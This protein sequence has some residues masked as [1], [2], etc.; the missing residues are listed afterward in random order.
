M[1][2]GQGAFEYLMTY[3]WAILVVLVIGVALWY[4]GV[5]SVG[6]GGVNRASGFAKMKVA[7][8]TIQ[9]SDSGNLLK[10]II[11]N[12]AGTGIEDVTATIIGGDHG[13]NN[14]TGK[15]GKTVLIEGETTEVIFG[16]GSAVADQCTKVGGSSFL[17]QVQI[18]YTQ[19]LMGTV[20]HRS[21]TGIIS[22]TVEQ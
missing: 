16:G 13:C 18:N 1:K 10:F 12:G 15:L 20:Y 22:G 6:T 2:K 3:G 4:L 14:L 7:D 11:V 19:S 8:P 21:D 9:Y 5:F 17:A